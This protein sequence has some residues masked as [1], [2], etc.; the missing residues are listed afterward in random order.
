M[1][2]KEFT[3]ILRR[4]VGRIISRASP[5]TGRHL[6]DNYQRSSH[7]HREF[8]FV[9]SGTS[10]YLCNDSVYPCS[11]GTLFLFDSGI[12]HGHKY[13]WEDNH[14][15]HMWGYFNSNGLH[16]SCVN[17]MEHGQYHLIP[18]LSFIFLPEELL[19][20]VETRW[21]LLARLENPTE[22]V[23]ERYMK[24][25]MDAVL[26][27]VAFLITEHDAGGRKPTEMEKIER[28]IDSRN[29]NGCSLEHLA[30]LLGCTR[31]HF[32][33]KFHEK[34]G[35]TVGKYIDQ[36]RIKYVLW[37]RK[38]GISQKEIAYELGFSSPSSFWNWLQKHRKEL[39]H[40]DKSKSKK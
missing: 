1:G 22:E 5:S 3:E 9:V 23:V 4:G 40:E 31:C 16:V 28:Y 32:A 15:L 17:V 27:E 12:P 39:P 6:K 8:L 26:D 7:P 29:G 35:I 30:S 18:E 34:T 21:N 33:H 14:L 10:R 36:V 11:S 25:P 2:I 37:A 20:F 24:G 13:T 38:R 19:Q